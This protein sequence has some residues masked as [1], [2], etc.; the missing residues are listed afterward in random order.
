MHKYYISIL[1]PDCQSV[2]NSHVLVSCILHCAYPV[3]ATA[4]LIVSRWWV[5]ECRHS[6]WPPWVCREALYRGRCMGPCGE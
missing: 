5:W 4:S 2:S 6:T 3:D 1:F